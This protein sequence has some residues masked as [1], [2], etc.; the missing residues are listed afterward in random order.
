MASGAQRI[1]AG[2][3]FPSG[4][5]N[6]RG[7]SSLGLRA[8]RSVRIVRDTTNAGKG[9]DFHGRN[10]STGI[11]PRAW[12][13]DVVIIDLA[14]EFQRSGVSPGVGVAGRR[15]RAQIGRAHV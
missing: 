10:G 7:G 4:S 5:R 9:R 13:V 8:I 14:Q 15:R 12:R 11:S 1:A 3:M 2:T 6:S